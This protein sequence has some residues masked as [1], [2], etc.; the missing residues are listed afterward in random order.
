MDTRL[1]NTPPPLADIVSECQVLCPAGSSI[2]QGIVLLC[3]EWV[4]AYTPGQPQVG[5]K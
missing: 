4:D 2:L 5:I 1:K 3:Y